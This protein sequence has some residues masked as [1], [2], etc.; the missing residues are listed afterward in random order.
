MRGRL[1]QI[2]GQRVAA[3]LIVVSL[4]ASRMTAHE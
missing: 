4:L 3:L 1:P 2:Q